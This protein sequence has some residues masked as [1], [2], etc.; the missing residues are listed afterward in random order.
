MA[1]TTSP[2]LN[3]L[4]E[5]AFV[6]D[7]SADTTIEVNVRGGP[8]T[9]YQAF[10]DNSALAAIVYLKIWDAKQPVNGTTDPDF[11]ILIPAS[12][13]VTIGFGVDGEDFDLGL[14]F[15]V[16]DTAGT[17]AGSAPATPPTVRLVCT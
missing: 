15:A 6:V 12:T 1:V 16:S 14:S 8:T 2:F 7:T 5:Q 11:G 3:N 10:V 17:G 13:R 9:L 4:L